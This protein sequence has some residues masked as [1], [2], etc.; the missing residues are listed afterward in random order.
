MNNDET[1]TPW[2]VLFEKPAPLP[3]DLETLR[4]HFRNVYK[5]KDEQVEFMM[6]SASQSLHTALASAE[7]ALV[8]DNICVA[9]APVAH[10]LK[11]L[12]LNMGEEGWASVARAMELSAKAGQVY[13]YDQVVRKI[14][15]GAEAIMVDSQG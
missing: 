9:L 13:E 2:Q 12:F 6:K 5:L 11:G 3:L 14:R 4:N 8:C 10:G 15:Q 7:Q 1:V